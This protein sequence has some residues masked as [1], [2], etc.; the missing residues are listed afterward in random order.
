MKKMN[1]A[2]LGVKEVSEKELR[3]IDGGISI[4]FMIGRLD[5]SRKD[6]WNFFWE[7]DPK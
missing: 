6:K 3:K 1:L 7:K 5:T 4:N 2:T